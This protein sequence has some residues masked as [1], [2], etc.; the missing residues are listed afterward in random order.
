[1]LDR[2]I[3]WKGVASFRK[4]L[5][6]KISKSIGLTTQELCRRTSLIKEINDF[7]KNLKA[8]NFRFTT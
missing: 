8:E 4:K 1:M 7:V 5:T 6:K 2:E 3:I